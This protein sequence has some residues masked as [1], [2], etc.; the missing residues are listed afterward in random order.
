LH[1][2]TGPG[3]GVTLVHEVLREILM[4]GEPWWD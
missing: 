1:V 3:L 2:P 4:P